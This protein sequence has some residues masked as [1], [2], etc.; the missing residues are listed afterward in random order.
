MLKNN[1]YKNKDNMLVNGVRFLEN[2]V[3]HNKVM[4]NCIKLMTTFL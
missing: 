1:V 2:T 3:V 4:M